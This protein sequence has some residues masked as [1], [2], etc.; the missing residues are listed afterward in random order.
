MSSAA[1]VPF[2]DATNLTR[3]AWDLLE[4]ERNDLGLP[5]LA[6]QPVDSFVNAAEQ[7]PTTCAER[8]SIMDQAA[9]MFN[10]LYPHLPFKTDI[11]HFIHPWQDFLDQNVR[12]TCGT[13]GESDFHDFI[14]AA[15]SLVRDAHTLYVKPSPYRDAVAFLPFQMHPYEDQTGRHY[16]VTKVMKSQPDGG[17]GHPFFGPGG[18]RSSSGE[19]KPST[20]TCKERRAVCPAATPRRPSPAARFTARCAL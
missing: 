3:Q 17:F 6:I 16:I 12:P 5:A 10:H 9:L 20:I 8:E 14:V 11:Y 18:G 19:E 7:N 1:A 13:L 2:D 4:A 15:F